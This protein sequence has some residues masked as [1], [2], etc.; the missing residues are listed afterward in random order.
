MTVLQESPNRG[1][2]AQNKS[3]ERANS[4]PIE[5]AR[6]NFQEGTYAPTP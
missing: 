1:R 6:S 5:L 2:T 4:V 3:I